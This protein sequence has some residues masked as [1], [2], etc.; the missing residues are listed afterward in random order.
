[1]KPA[2]GGE[3]SGGD[4]GAMVGVDSGVFVEGSA[5]GAS[6]VGLGVDVETGVTSEA[7]RVVGV[8]VGVGEADAF[9]RVGDDV[10][11][12]ISGSGVRVGAGVDV[13][14]DVGVCPISGNAV[15]APSGSD[16]RA[17]KIAPITISPR[18]A[19]GIM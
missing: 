13:G 7:G 5:V 19:M 2:G 1:M 9:V 12:G 14:I 16:E 4:V 11:V 15:A 17:I 6:D 18:P 3:V 8:G 10:R